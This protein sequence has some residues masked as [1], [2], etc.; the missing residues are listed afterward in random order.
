M[1]KHRYLLQL[2]NEFNQTKCNGKL[3]AAQKHRLLTIHKTGAGIEEA[4]SDDDMQYLNYQ[5]SLIES[6]HAKGT[7]EKLE[8]EFNNLSAVYGDGV[9][10]SMFMW[11]FLKGQHN[12]YLLTSKMLQ[13]VTSTQ[14]LKNMRNAWGKAMAAVS[15]IVHVIEKNRR[16]QLDR[17]KVE[18]AEAYRRSHVAALAYKHAL[19]HHF[20]S[21]ACLYDDIE[22]CL[23]TLKASKVT[24]DELE[25]LL[26]LLYLKYLIGAFEACNNGERVLII[27]EQLRLLSTLVIFLRRELASETNEQCIDAVKK[28]LGV[29]YYLDEKKESGSEHEDIQAG[30]EKFKQY[31]AE[32]ASEVDSYLLHDD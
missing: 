21:H 26:D 13:D 20:K 8:D 10:A 6:T 12:A 18:M 4:I 19:G 25:P 17:G 28:I 16:D 2:I 1:G 32:Y 9:E 24:L 5:I 31:F 14:T 30:I 3:T 15:T 11:R 27:D 23:D 29:L 22:W 7:D